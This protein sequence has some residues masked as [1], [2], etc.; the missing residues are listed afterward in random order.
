MTP[1]DPAVYIPQEP[2]VNRIFA[3]LRQL[4]KT[5]GA[6]HGEER[7]FQDLA[8]KLTEHLGIKVTPQK[9]AQWATASDNR[10]P[11]WGAI[12][13]LMHATGYEVTL[14]VGGSGAKLVR[15]KAETTGEA[16]SQE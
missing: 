8:D 4:W 3:T 14:T 5:Q 10:R 12:Y 13:W 9:L 15:P 2:P 11:P 7:K 16:A 1:G 6:D